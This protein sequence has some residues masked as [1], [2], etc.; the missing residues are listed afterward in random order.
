MTPPE[1][2][3][4]ELEALLEQYATVLEFP[5]KKVFHEP[6]DVLDGVY[7]I[8]EGRTRHYIIGVDGSEKVLYTL[9][10]GWFYGETPCDLD[11]PTGL[12]SKTEVKSRL[13]HIPIDRYEELI[14]SNEL[15]RKTILH[16]YAKKL[17]ILRQEIENLVFSS[18][19][20]R[21]KRLYCTTADTSCTIDGQWY[22]MKV[23]Y[24]QYE[25]STIVSGARVTVSKLINELC[26]EGFLRVVNRHPQISVR[27]YEEERAKM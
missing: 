10:P 13:L 23:N 11:E 26:A 20:E 15:F 1:T 27:A 19:K 6:G 14:N 17:R 21:I 24:T 16:S 7:Y 8:A 9:S 5:A 4:R 18:C 2:N 22:G 25:I 3:R 12:Y